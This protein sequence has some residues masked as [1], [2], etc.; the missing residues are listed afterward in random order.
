MVNVSKIL[1]VKAT[2]SQF[3]RASSQPPS[4]NHVIGKSYE[5]IMQ[6]IAEH[7]KGEF[8][9]TYDRYGRLTIVGEAKRKQDLISRGLDFMTTLKEF[10]EHSHK[11]SIQSAVE[12]TDAIRKGKSIPKWSLKLK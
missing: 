2:R 10:F 5:K 9:K 1:Y 11:L 3:A 6:E 7:E 8:Y 12:I 4:F